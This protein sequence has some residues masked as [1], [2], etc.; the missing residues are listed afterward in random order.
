MVAPLSPD[1]ARLAAIREA[2]PA[3]GA[4]I[5]L[6]TAAAGPLPADAVRVMADLAAAELTLGRGH[7]HD[8]LETIERIGEARASLA[9]VL[10][11]DLDSVALVRGAAHGTTL[12]ITAAAPRPGE[13]V[14]VVRGEGEAA[15]DR[16]V[17][18]ME[19]AGATVTSIRSRAE[20]GPDVL[21]GAVRQACE[22]TTA[23][24]TAVLLPLVTT[25]TGDR[26]P[27]AEIASAAHAAGGRVIAD[28]G[29]AVGAIP[30][31]PG[32]LGVDAIAFAA[33][34][35]LLGPADLGG[36][37]CGPAMLDRIRTLEPLAFADG[38]LRFGGEG[39]AWVHE[40]TA[41]ARPAVAG[42][43]R[44]AGWLAMQVGLPWAWERTAGL[45]GRAA[46]ALA[47]ISGVTILTPQGRP[48]A[49]VTFRIDGWSAREA[50]DE[51][52]ARVFAIAG[53]CPALEAVRISLGC[54]T[55]EDELDRFVAGVALLA[56]HTPATI[57][58]R[59]SLSVLP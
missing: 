28:G 51:L 56:A 34:R 26:L 37:W 17:A 53:P 54:W 15:D 6:N 35:W 50:V 16:A 20:D 18:A 13:A 12:A 19:A 42:L 49:I 10:A 23:R 5:Y 32:S 29:M 8:P 58:P 41:I 46:A 47:A 9:A 30:V 2:L 48:A 3:T 21:V 44:S 11:A 40:A 59:R 38:L 55:T 27:V 43:A 31:D 45:V 36:L 24:L 22:G 52:G 1:Q 7:A 14:I 57:P 39:P 4:G 25:W 33:E